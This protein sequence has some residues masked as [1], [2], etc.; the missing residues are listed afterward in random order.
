MIL[1]SSLTETQTLPLYDEPLLALCIGASKY[2]TDEKTGRS[3]ATGIYKKPVSDRLFLTY[4]GFEDDHQA[5]KV[6]H[7]GPDK[8]VHLYPFDHYAF[9]ANHYGHDYFTQKGQFGENFSTLF[10]DEHTVSIGDQ[11]QIGGAKIEVSQAR[12]PCWKLNARFGLNDLANR[13]VMTGK[14]GWYFRVF[15]EGLVQTGDRLVLIDRPHAAFSLARVFGAL[16]RHEGSVEDYEA[17]SRLSPLF[18]P[19]RE[20]SLKK[21]SNLRDKALNSG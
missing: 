17:I 19:W 1:M 20:I 7:G 4:L 18:A 8:A 9:W 15:E 10:L 5:D 21:L 6:F 14:T 16:F 3:E 2:L 12:Q 11:F 13:I